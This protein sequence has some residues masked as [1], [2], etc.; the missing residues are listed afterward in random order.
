MSLEAYG[1]SESGC[2]RENNEDRVLLDA[3]L[4]LF[5][6][7]DGMG[8]H[9]HGEVAAEL[10]VTAVRYYVDASRDRLDVSWPF[11]YNFELSLDANRLITSLRFANRQVWRRSEQNLECAGMGTTIAAVLLSED[12]AV[13][14]NIGDSRIYLF[15]DGELQQVSI[16][17]TMIATLLQR[18]VLSTA[19][20][21]KH[22]MRNVLTQ[23]AGAQDHVEIHISEHELR[24]GDTLLLC[25]DGLHGVV[26]PT[27]IRSILGGGDNV[28]RSTDRLIA[29]AVAAGAP[30][31]VSV[32]LLRHN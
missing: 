12:R 22:P 3:G 23:S 27:T 11:G 5:L 7:C 16:D 13:V 19:D 17:D 4:G 25:S 32:I 30:D 26:D 2:V 21:A 28:E 31:N 24:Q 8:G 20:A 6:L 18:G 29:A 14:A 15:R 9:Q 10:A 1:I